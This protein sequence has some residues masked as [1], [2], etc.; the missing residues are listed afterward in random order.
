MTIWESL[1]LALAAALAGFLIGRRVRA[2]DER[3]VAER[4]VEDLLRS[5]RE[6]ADRLIRIEAALSDMQAALRASMRPVEDD[7]ASTADHGTRLTASPTESNTVLPEGPA[8]DIAPFPPFHGSDRQEYAVQTGIGVRGPGGESAPADRALSVE[9]AAVLFHSSWRRG[10]RP[11]KPAGLEVSSL[12]F[13]RASSDNPSADARGEFE[14]C[15][16]I[17]DFLRIGGMGEELAF[18]FVHPA[19]I[20]NPEVVRFLHPGVSPD[21]DADALR[22]LPPVRLRRSG[23]FWVKA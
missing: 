6:G 12:R 10:E 16:Q 20:P 11:P 8:E 22:N 1:A 3:Y 9:D 17:A 13:R 7:P 18:A 14:D 21:A 15:E 5:A 4:V 19:A 23:Q 2:V